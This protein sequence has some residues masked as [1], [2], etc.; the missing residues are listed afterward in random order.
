MSQ[1][2]IVYKRNKVESQFTEIG[3]ALCS[4]NACRFNLTLSAEPVRKWLGDEGEKATQLTSAEC[5]S[6]FAVG[7]LPDEPDPLVSHL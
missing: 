3:G 7:W 1:R 4:S 2:P 5:A 6:I